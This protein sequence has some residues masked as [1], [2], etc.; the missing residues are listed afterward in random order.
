MAALT[1]SSTICSSGTGNSSANW[2]IKKCA[3]LQGTASTS[4]PISHS[5]SKSAFSFGSG[6]SPLPKIAV[7]RSG[8]SQSPI[9][10]TTG[11]SW[12]QFAGHLIVNWRK[13]SAAAAGPRPPTTPNFLPFFIIFF[14]L[15]Y[16]SSFLFSIAYRINKLLIILAHRA[17]ICKYHLLYPH[18]KSRCRPPRKVTSNG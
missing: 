9:I 6:D 4:A 14:S 7:P 11:C 13:N 1:V 5:C 3:V 10:Y 12:S 8:I 18:T 16:T 17:V 2:S 15:I